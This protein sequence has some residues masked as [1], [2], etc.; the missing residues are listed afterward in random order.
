MLTGTGRQEVLTAAHEGSDHAEQA[1]QHDIGEA[2]LEQLR[3]D[4]ARLS[5]QADTGEPLP[6]FGDMRRVRDRIHRMLDRRLWPR[7]RTDLYLVLGCVS[8]LMG[9]T[10][11]RLGHPETAEELIRTGWAYANALD[12][13]PLRGVLRA[14]LSGIQYWRGRFGE[15]RDLAADGLRYV[16]QGPLG[17]TLHLSL[18]RASARFGDPDAA[19]QAVDAAHDAREREYSDDLLAIGGEEFA[20]S[21]ATHHCLAGAALAEIIGS[22]RR[23][24]EELE[25]ARNRYDAGPAAGEQHWSGGEP[26]AGI[27]LAM[28]RLRSGGLDPAAAALEPALSLP[29]A[30]RVT[31][32]TT[33]LARVREELTAPIFRGSAQARDLGDQIEEFAREA[34]AASQPEGWNHR[35]SCLWARQAGD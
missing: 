7:E 31:P 1:E 2:T 33:L 5:R 4:L 10:A 14:K 18:A 27:C 19:G 22:E 34:I 6:V 15:S 12:H 21:L 11:S 32:L 16:S 28:I 25:H 3:A 26:F 24:E 20:L 35:R 30:R 17:A 13:K 23:A 9:V 8:G 29:P